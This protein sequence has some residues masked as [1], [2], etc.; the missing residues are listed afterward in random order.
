MKTEYV[1]M[2]GA[3]LLIVVSF[4]LGFIAAYIFYEYHEQPNSP[5]ISYEQKTK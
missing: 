4:A 3:R 5:T 2:N 1:T